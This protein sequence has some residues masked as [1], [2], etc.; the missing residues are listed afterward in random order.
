METQRTASFTNFTSEDFTYYWDGKA[1]TIKAGKS[2]F[3]PEFLARV[4]AKHLVNRELQR[5]DR[6]GELIYK[7]GDKFVSPKKPE[8]IP[9]F[10]ELFKKAFKLEEEDTEEDEKQD[11]LDSEMDILNKNRA[12]TPSQ[13]D[14]D[15]DD[16]ESAFSNLPTNDEPTENTE[17]TGFETDGPSV[18]TN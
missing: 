6:A 14:D 11:D 1:R 13:D 5:K 7:N 16:D 4:S 15:E 18:Q 17:R 2:K 8:E 10:M 9:V 12:N 3:M